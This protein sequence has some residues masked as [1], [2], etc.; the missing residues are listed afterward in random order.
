YFDQI[1]TIPAAFR[2][3]GKGASIQIHTD[4]LFYTQL[5]KDIEDLTAL[6]DKRRNTEMHGYISSGGLGN[7]HV[8]AIEMSEEFALD[9]WSTV[10]LLPVTDEKQEYT[11]RRAGRI[12]PSF[13]LCCLSLS[14]LQFLEPFEDRIFERIGLS[15]DQ[16]RRCMVAIKRYFYIGWHAGS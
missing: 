16:L 13:T 2:R 4:G 1:S 8:Q 6:Y 12:S 5:D 11:I 14:P 15:V 7:F 10:A 9:P 3:A